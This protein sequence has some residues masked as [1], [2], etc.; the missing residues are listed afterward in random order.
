VLDVVPRVVAV[1][2]GVAVVALAPTVAA[3]SPLLAIDR[4]NPM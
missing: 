4:V 1:A 3:A 2:D